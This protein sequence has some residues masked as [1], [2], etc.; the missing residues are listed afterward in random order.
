MEDGPQRQAMNLS[1]LGLGEARRGG[2]SHSH[3]SAACHGHSHAGAG[4]DAGARAGAGDDDGM[5]EGEQQ[6]EDEAADEGE[7]GSETGSTFSA[8]GL[9]DPSLGELLGALE[10]PLVL[11]RNLTRVADSP[12]ERFQLEKAFWAT[13]LAELGSLSAEYEAQLSC[14]LTSDGELLIRYLEVSADEEP[15][16]ESFVAF[17]L[18]VLA[19]AKLRTAAAM[20]PFPDLV[21][22]II[23]LTPGAAKT[24]ATREA[25]ETEQVE[26]EEEVVAAALEQQRQRQQQQHRQVKKADRHWIIVEDWT[27]GRAASRAQQLVLYGETPELA[28]M[29]LLLSKA[30][31]ELGDRLLESSFREPW[32][33]AS[34]EEDE[35]NAG[36]LARRL[37]LS[38]SDEEGDG[39]GRWQGKDD[40]IENMPLLD[41]SKYRQPSSA[42]P[43]R[44]FG[45][46]PW[47]LAPPRPLSPREPDLFGSAELFEPLPVQ[48]DGAGQAEDT[49]EL[50]SLLA[51][52]AELGLGAG[53]G[54]NIM[55][56]ANGFSSSDDIG[57]L[58]GA[59][60][61]LQEPP[62][63]ARFAD[64]EHDDVRF[65]SE[66]Q[67][68]ARDAD[69]IASDL[70]ATADAELGSLD[71]FEWAEPKR[72]EQGGPSRTGR[73]A[74]V[75]A[76][77]AVPDP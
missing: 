70:I 57:A 8:D 53:G 41:D 7:T 76:A 49:G 25:A 66:R 6:E 16:R 69:S 58:L 19:D 33:E 72:A 60:A 75:A 61:Q 32:E 77:A 21:A 18:A 2:H 52:F 20:H 42:V 27:G 9:V 14:E 34:D 47:R 39:D 29:A 1:A 62:D 67:E 74:A 22:M 17:P 50:M 13:D 11:P 65:G 54:E 5:E 23:E 40:D 73:H 59:L 30:R 45:G 63:T 36:E 24:F 38:S 37:G 35:E 68:R 15:V 28:E 64:A 31:P 10:S 51:D 48:L 55:G 26:G 44:R 12:R 3:A 71:D 56:S 43:A 4:A 46:K